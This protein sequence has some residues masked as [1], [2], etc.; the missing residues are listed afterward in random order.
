MQTFNNHHAL[1]I[2]NVL[3]CGDANC[4]TSKTSGKNA[5]INKLNTVCR[6]IGI[7]DLRCSNMN[8]CPGIHGV[9]LKM[10]KKVE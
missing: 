4:I 8:I 6:N 5:I 1:K 3:L 9:M 7:C 10:Y 2:E